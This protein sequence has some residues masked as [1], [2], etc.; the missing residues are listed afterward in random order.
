VNRYTTERGYRQHV[1]ALV[2]DM[3]RAGD[4]II[5]DAALKNG[6]R[7][8]VYMPFWARGPH[9]QPRFVLIPPIWHEREV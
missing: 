1:S 3:R 2:N 5:V 7:F 4:R 9:T 8:I 6:G